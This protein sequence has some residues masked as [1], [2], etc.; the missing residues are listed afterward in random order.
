MNTRDEPEGT[1]KYLPKI[2]LLIAA[3]LFGLNTV[4]VPPS[5][6]SEF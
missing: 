5:A 6:G 1:M 2:T 4:F 3:L